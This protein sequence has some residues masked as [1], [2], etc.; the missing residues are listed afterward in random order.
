MLVLHHVPWLCSWPTPEYQATASHSIVAQDTGGKQMLAT[1]QHI[2]MLQDVI[3]CRG[4][5]TN[6]DGTGVVFCEVK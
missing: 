6:S 5:T 3:S 2:K 4:A 1:F